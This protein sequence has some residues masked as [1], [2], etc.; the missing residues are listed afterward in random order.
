LL[1]ATGETLVAL[2]ETVRDTMTPSYPEI[3]ENWDRIRR[4]TVT[5]EKAFL[6]TLEAGTRLF[7]DVAAQAKATGA[8]TLAGS[9][10]FTLHDTHGF[11]ID[12]TMEM[13]AEAGLE[14]DRAEFDREMAEQR[15][16]AKA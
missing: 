11:P 6:K 9:D 5:E 1:G 12:L 14:V 3:T 10:A 13:A 7:E 8:T 2:M 16:R 15:A 4:V